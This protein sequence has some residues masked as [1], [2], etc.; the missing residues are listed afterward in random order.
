MTVVVFVSGVSLSIMH[1][2]TGH[3]IAEVANNSIQLPINSTD[4]Y[5]IECVSTRPRPFDTVTLQVS[6]LDNSVVEQ[7]IHSHE[8][9]GLNPGNG[10]LPTTTL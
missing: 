2:E 1:L 10:E 4:L 3:L 6:W 7:W 5:R 8:N 9:M